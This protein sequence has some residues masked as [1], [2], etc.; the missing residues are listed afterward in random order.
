MPAL[1]I[2]E[3]PVIKRFFASEQGSGLRQDAYELYREINKVV[4]TSNKLKK[5]GRIEELNSYL[6]SKQHLLDIKSPVYNIKK[7]LDKIRRSRDAIMRMDISSERKREMID[8][9][10]ESI[11]EMLKVVPALKKKADELNQQVEGIIN[12]INQLE[13][14]D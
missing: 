7:K 4:T 13:T 2:Y 14:R 11:N 10:D 8:D 5:E 9:L 3:Y 1:K 6:G 12:R